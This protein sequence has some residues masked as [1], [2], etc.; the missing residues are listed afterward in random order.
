MDHSG[1]KRPSKS[2]G[3]FKNS[4]HLFCLYFAYLIPLVSFITFPYFLFFSVYST[5]LVKVSLPYFKTSSGLIRQWMQGWLALMTCLS[6]DI[7]IPHMYVTAIQYHNWKELAVRVARR[8]YLNLSTWRLC[9]LS[10]TICT[11]NL[12]NFHLLIMNS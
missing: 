11:P 2:L 6:P 8:I 10:K 3:A 4:S 9:S 5:H 7:S 1:A 12:H